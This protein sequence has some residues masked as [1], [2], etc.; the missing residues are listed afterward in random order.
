MGNFLGGSTV[1]TRIRNYP[2]SFF[3]DYMEKIILKL[4]LKD[5]EFLL[6][7]FQKKEIQNGKNI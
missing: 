6:R 1:Y 4:A 2:W 3:I 7:T 5:T